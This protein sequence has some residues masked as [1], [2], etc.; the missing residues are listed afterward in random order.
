MT[1]GGT[2]TLEGSGNNSRIDGVAGSPTFTIADQTIQGHGNIGTNTL[3]IINGANGVI[4]ANS[5]GNTLTIDPSNAGNFVNAGTIRAMGAGELLLTGSGGGTFSGG[6]VYEALDSGL[7][8]ADST[9]VVS[10]LAGGVLT[11]GTWR[12][13]D[14]GL[15]AGIW[16]Q[17]NT[18]SLIQSIGVNASVELSGVNSSFTV[19][20]TNS[21][22]L[23]ST[24]NQLQGGLTLRNGRV[25]NLTGGLDHDGALSLD[26]ATTALVVNGDFTQSSG[27][28]YLVN[29]A[30]LDLTAGASNALAGGLIGGNGTIVGD[31]VNSQ[32]QLAPGLSAGALSIDG[33]YTQAALGS[34]WIEIG[35]TAP[36]ISFD[37]LNIT[38]NASLDGTLMVSLLGGYTPDATDSFEILTAGM[39]SGVFSNAPLQ[40]EIQGGGFFDV[41]YTGG[42]VFLGNFNAVPEPAAGLLLAVA[43]GI[44]AGARRRRD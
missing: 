18:T 24:L 38:G 20:T 5:A 13:I 9:A 3:G 14:D 31:L 2:I 30:T 28:T 21:R 39:L 29:G 37:Q 44:M 43:A 32:G 42:S 23:D 15:D 12:A 19:R 17:S 6:G 7:L 25:M 10:S 16:L 8:R 1:G 35:G 26:G 33:N 22:S 41:T 34:L 4:Q 11:E 36:G 27:T 40:V